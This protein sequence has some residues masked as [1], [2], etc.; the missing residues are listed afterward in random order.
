MNTT[1]TN[2]IVTGTLLLLGVAAWRAQLM[3]PARAQA[4]ADDAERQRATRIERGSYL[5]A[6][7][8]CNDCHTPMKL[9]D[10]GPEPDMTRM[11]SGHPQFMQL[12][13]PPAA[14]GP[15]NVSAAATMTAWSGPW[16][17]SFT[18]NLTSD[19]ETGLGAWS[20]Q[21]FVDTI[22]K[23]RHLGSGRPVLPPMPIPAYMHFSDEDL[24]SIY[25]YL[26]T[27]PAVKNRV[28]APLPPAAT[29]AAR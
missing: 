24:R 15:W 28:P 1:K 6:T 20:E 9:G 21:N 18:A 29:V 22:R 27:V 25:A 23:G 10:K 2:L 7:A 19:K 5:V 11:L 12:P 17:T 26:Q 8:G 13:K 16:G 4:S 3:Q 14:L